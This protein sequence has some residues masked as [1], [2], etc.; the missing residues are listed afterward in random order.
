MPRVSAHAA[1]PCPGYRY[2]AVLLLHEEVKRFLFEQSGSFAAAANAA[3]S[4]SDLDRNSFAHTV[5]SAARAKAAAAATQKAMATHQPRSP[6]Q[7]PPRASQPCS[8]RF[9]DAVEA[10][11][12]AKASV[13]EAAGCGV[14][15][16]SLSLVP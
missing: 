6:Q 4:R 1:S 8:V 15:T 9:E 16:D 12:H 14:R 5:V 13:L 2:V 3:S 10:P 11:S 7:S